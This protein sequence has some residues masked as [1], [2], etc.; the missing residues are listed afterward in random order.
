MHSVKYGTNGDCSKSKEFYPPA[1]STCWNRTWINANSN[2]N[3]WGNF[4]LLPHPFRFAP[5]EHS[6]ILLYVLYTS[7]LPK[8]RKSTLATFTDDPTIFATHEVPMI[9]SLNVQEQLHIIEK[10]LNKWKI[11]FNESKSLHVTF[12]LRNGP[13]PAVNINYHN[14]NRSSKIPCATLRVQVTL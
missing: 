12:P 14:S 2:K 8:S 4:K 6:W 13:C 7:D 10:L 3:Q 5:R 11:H 1:T 9:A